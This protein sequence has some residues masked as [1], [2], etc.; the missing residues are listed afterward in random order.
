VK[1]LASSQQGNQISIPITSEEFKPTNHEWVSWGG[2]LSQWNIYLFAC[3]FVYI[4]ICSFIIFYFAAQE[5]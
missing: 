1:P 2:D 3:L 5:I 4:S